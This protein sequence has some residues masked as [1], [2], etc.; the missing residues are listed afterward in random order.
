MAGDGLST[1]YFDNTNSTCA[2][3]AA[4][5]P[6]GDDYIEA[7]PPGVVGDFSTRWAGQLSAI[8]GG[9][10]TFQ[11][12]VNGGVKLWVNDK[13]LINQPTPQVA[14]RTSAPSPSKPAPITTSSSNT[15][16]PPTVTN[17]ALHSTGPVPAKPRLS[18]SPS[19]PTPP[20]TARSPP[21]PAS[22]TSAPS[23]PSATESTMTPKKSKPHSTPPEPHLGA[24]SFT[25]PAAPTA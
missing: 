13:L 1:V 10:Y 6:V 4:V 21:T 22:S 19:S 17:R 9:N 23:A 16:H 3:G 2:H 8:E 20:T 7:L 25:S 24:A 18:K 12:P 15:S 14:T 11:I 5:T